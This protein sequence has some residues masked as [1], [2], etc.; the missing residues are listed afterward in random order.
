LLLGVLL[1]AGCASGTSAG[2]PASGVTGAL[3]GGGATLSTTSTGPT[4]TESSATGPSA[5]EP[6]PNSPATRPSASP[7]DPVS[8]SGRPITLAFAGDVHFADQVAALLNRPQSS[9]ASLRPELAT[10]DLSMVNLETA[11][12]G[13]GSPAPK[14]YHFR[15]TPA[16]LTALAAAGVD[17]V[18]MA[19]NHSVDYGP[20]GLQDSLAAQRASKLPI[21]GFGADAVHAYA[22]AMF[23]VRGSR[24][25]VF[26]ASQVNDWT[27]Q[28]WTA[29]AG[30][31]GLA[32]SL[33]GSPL[34]AAVRS[35]RSRADLVVVFLHWGT[36]GQSC[37][38][39][40]QQQTARTLTSAG[41][42]IVIGSHAH[43]VQ[44]AGW[45]GRAFVGYGMGNFVWYNSSGYGS[46]TS[47][48]L[49]LTVK[50]RYVVSTAW[51]P[52]RI[53]SDGVPRVPDAG[54]R[55]QLLSAWE[56]TRRC[57]GLSLSPPTG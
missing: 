23:T 53:G 38:D 31:P 34:A 22:P 37:P 19:N 26:G 47:G 24:I 10:A 8:G 14:T 45:M 32:S 42:D 17:V 29:T 52:M 16:A 49:I 46:S 56:Q 57:T 35:A 5:T 15:T 12:T 20:V 44:G 2:P 13:R 48:V 41:A 1:V 18:T 39:S 7:S 51:T 55:A 36:E 30:K 50:G 25:A 43:R 21:V 4:S 33:P 9:L 40:L 54:T 6:S 3:Q 28:N 11:I 27:L